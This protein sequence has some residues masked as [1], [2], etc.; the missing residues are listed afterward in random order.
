VLGNG[1]QR[2]N[3]EP[4]YSIRRFQIEHT[5]QRDDALERVW[6]FVKPPKDKKEDYLYYMM[7]IRLSE[8][9]VAEGLGFVLLETEDMPWS[10]YVDISRHMWD[11]MRHSLF[12]E[13]A[14]EDTYGDRRALPMR[15]YEA[16]YAYSAD[17]LEQYAT[18]GLEIEGANMKYP[19][20]KRWEWEFARDEA[21]HPL[22][23]TFQDFDW[24]D[25]VLHVNIARRQ[26][27]EWF[28]G[29][30]K[31]IAPFSKDGKKNRDAIKKSKPQLNIKPKL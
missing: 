22:M 28:D 31:A 30:L 10:F 5:V 25:E 4:K 12:G 17:P 21:N 11:E 23:T 8:I 9:N 2:K 6:D 14:I 1:Q 18:L 7:A 29:G 20:G 13:A 19:P 15:D 3:L 27:D 24:A 26:L 16:V